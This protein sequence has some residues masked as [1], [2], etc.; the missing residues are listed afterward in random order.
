MKRTYYFIWG[1]AALLFVILVRSNGIIGP[2]VAGVPSQSS[3]ADAATTST[4][5]ADGLYVAP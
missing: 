4:P 2:S 1:L 5:A 3:A